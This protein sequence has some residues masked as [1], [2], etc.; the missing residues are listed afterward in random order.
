M[1]T[2]TLCNAN[3]S[4]LSSTTLQVT[5][6]TYITDEEINELSIETLKDLQK[7]INEAVASYDARKDAEKR[8]A[9]IELLEQN[10]FTGEDILNY[11]KAE[12]TVK[13]N[14]LYRNPSNPSQTWVGKGKRPNWFNAALDSGK[15]KEDMI[16]NTLN[17]DMPT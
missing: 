1:L 10:G 7:R 3:I 17:L 8:K 6:M 12:K 5:I 13:T 4:L 14:V 9:I 11:I 2:L 16:D 15:T